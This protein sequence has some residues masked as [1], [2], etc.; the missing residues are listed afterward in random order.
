MGW[1]WWFGGLGVVSSSGRYWFGRALLAGLGFVGWLVGWVALGVVAL[2]GW[3]GVLLIGLGAVAWFWVSLVWLGA[4]DW[5]GYLY[6]CS[7]MYLCLLSVDM[8]L[9]AILQI[10]MHA[11]IHY[12]YVLCFLWRYVSMNMHITNILRVVRFG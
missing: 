11:C 4:V 7:Y 1:V 12:K 8:S 6:V 2:F 3:V 10:C 9:V 5:L